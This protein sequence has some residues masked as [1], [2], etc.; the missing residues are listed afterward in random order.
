MPELDDQI[1]RLYQLP[2]NQF[3]AARNALAKDAQ[4]PAVKD[5]EKPNIA[6]WAVNQWYW[7]H[8]TDYDRLTRSSERLRDEHRKLLAGKPADLRE[9]ERVHRDA[10][11]TAAER[12]RELLQEAGHVAT[13]QT[14]N[15]VQQ[16]LEALPAGGRPGRLTRPLQPLGFEALAGVSITNARRPQLRIVAPAKKP[17]EDARPGDLRRE[18]ELA[19]QREKEERAR[20]ERQRQHEKQLKAAEA[21][22]LRAEEAVKRAEKELAELRARRDAAVSEYQRARLRARE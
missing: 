1:D 6:A 22:M 20:K 19:R 16:T 4:R 9:A 18:R 8:R 17:G 21:A 7:R 5:L 14:L 3:T 13:D 15:A 12:I 2:L 11:R 10:I